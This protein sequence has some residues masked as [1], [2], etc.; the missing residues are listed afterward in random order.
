M[1]GRSLEKASRTSEAAGEYEKA[2]KLYKD[3]YLIDDLY[4]DETMVE[5]ERLIYI[6]TDLLKRLSLHYANIGQL[7]KSIST[8]YRILEKDYCDED[9]HRLLIECFVRLGLRTRALRQYRLCTTRLR[10]EYET[11]PSP[12]TQAL[13]RSVLSNESLRHPT[14]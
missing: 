3:D 4:E 11:E 14:A 2:A 9:T 13:Y 12:K 8:C 6:Y 10:Q 1:K 5:R 7:R